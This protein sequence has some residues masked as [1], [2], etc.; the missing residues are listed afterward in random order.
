M[1]KQFILPS[2][3]LTTSPPAASTLYS[4]YILEVTIFSQ[5]Y[6]KYLNYPTQDHSSTYSVNTP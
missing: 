4:Q 5:G 6:Q 2:L 1:L 3:P